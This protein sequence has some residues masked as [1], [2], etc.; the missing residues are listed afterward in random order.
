M[1]SLRAMAAVWESP[2]PLDTM[3]AIVLVRLADFADDHGGGIFP[4]VKRVAAECRLS[5]R[6]VQY[7][8]RDLEATGLLVKVAD[9]D[10]GR[11]RGREYRLDLGAL[12]QSPEGCTSCRGAGR[13]GVQVVR[14]KGARRAGVGVHDVHPEP[15]LDPPK[16]HQDLSGDLFGE[17]TPETAKVIAL[18]AKAKTPAKP[19]FPEEAFNEFWTVYPRKTDEDGTRAAYREALKK[20]ATQAGLI[21][22]AS[23]YAAAVA[24]DSTPTRYVKKPANFLRHGAWKDTPEDQSPHAVGNSS[25]RRQ[26]IQDAASRVFAD[27]PEARA[28]REAL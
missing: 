2:R 6:K 28:F 23:A 5:P 16:N 7:I 21:A 8:L 1:M 10:P 9:E 18:P 4:S 25:P 20:G 14:P 22:S 24:Q 11:R 13:A 27:T 12:S 3:T 19:S 26:S 15:P 17:Q